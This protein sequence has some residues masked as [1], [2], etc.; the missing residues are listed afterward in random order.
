MKC[1]IWECDKLAPYPLPCCGKEHGY[2]LKQI[3]AAMEARTE[4]YR[5]TPF[6]M[7]DSILSNKEIFYYLDKVYHATL[8]YNPAK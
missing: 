8:P 6:A 1:V 4:K 2:K 3:K 5:D 7:F